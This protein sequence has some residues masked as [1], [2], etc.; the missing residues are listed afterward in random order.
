MY[1][2]K[3]DFILKI[4]EFLYKWHNK[5]YSYW[6][7]RYNIRTRTRMKIIKVHIDK[8]KPNYVFSYIYLENTYFEV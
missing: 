7:P 1:N 2:A 8:S 6:Y 5:V 3:Y 4:L